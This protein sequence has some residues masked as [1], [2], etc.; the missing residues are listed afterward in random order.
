MAEDCEKKIFTCKDSPSGI[1]PPEPKQ[2]V[3]SSKGLN[4]V[5]VNATKFTVWNDTNVNV[6]WGQQLIIPGMSISY[7]ATYVDG[8]PACYVKDFSLSFASATHTGQV[9]VMPDVSD[10]TIP[11]TSGGGGTATAANQVLQIAQET[12]INTNTANTATNTGAGGTLDTDLQALITST[13]AKTDAANTNPATS[14][15]IIAFLK[16]IEAVLQAGINVGELSPNYVG[17]SKTVTNAAPTGAAFAPKWGTNSTQLAAT[18]TMQVVLAAGYAGGAIVVID[19]SQDGGTNWSELGP[20]LTIPAG[21]LVGAYTFRAGYWP[22]IRVR[23]VNAEG[24]TGTVTFN[25][26]YGQ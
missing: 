16:G 4:S 15:S 7:H 21:S 6:F 11:G 25:L 1:N 19:G 2:Y 20:E 24:G 10:P 26:S 13:G 8:K 22:Q 12:A 18:I 23:M 14:G 3:A 17:V 9:W 5:H